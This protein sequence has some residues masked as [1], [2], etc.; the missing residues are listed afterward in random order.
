[1][2]ENEEVN[3]TSDTELAFEGQTTFVYM[4]FFSTEMV[5]GHCYLRSRL[6]KIDRKEYEEKYA[7]R[8]PNR[9]PSKKKKKG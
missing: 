8:D 5:D 2:T 3:D 1:M 7:M 4:T 6:E 9:V